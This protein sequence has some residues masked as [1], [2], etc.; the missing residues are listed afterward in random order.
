MTILVFANGILSDVSWVRSL[1]VDSPII[2]AADGGFKHVRRLHLF[3]HVVIGDMDSLPPSL[4]DAP[5]LKDI[6][7]IEFSTDKDETD[8]EIAL[9]FAA[10]KYE[11]D[12]LVIGALGGRIDQTFANILSLTHPQ[13]RNRHIE[14]LEKN[15][16]AWLCL[17]ETTIKGS[18]GDLV[19]LI[20]LSG[21]VRVVNTTGLKW[22]LLNETLLFG[23]TRGISNE[24]TNPVATVHKLDGELLCVHQ[25][26]IEKF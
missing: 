3:P 7:F 8:L 21:K 2:I 4:D 19:S 1:L 22:P 10:S 16:R 5:E 18:V 9:Q 23:R 20:P 11:G 13:L 26:K 12:I 15:Q 24:M 17:T 14:I 25:R 6:E